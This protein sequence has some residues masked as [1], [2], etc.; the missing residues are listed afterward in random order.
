MQKKRILSG[1]RPTGDLHIGNYFG[2]VRQFVELQNQGHECFFFVADLHAL[3]TISK[4]TDLRGATIEIVRSYLACGLD[5][6][7]STIYCQSCLPEIPY[8]STLLGMATSES[9]LR[10]CTTFKEKSEKQEIVS[11]GLLSYPV[12][13]ATDILIVNSNIVPVGHDQLQHLEMTRDIAQKFNTTFGEVFAMPEARLMQAIRVPGLDGSGKMGKSDG[14]TISLFENPKS[15]I[16]KIKSAKTDLGPVAG[17]SM[18]PEIC[19]LFFLM[20]LCCP[21]EV[22]STYREKYNNLEQ[23]FYG[24]MKQDLA[25]YTVKFLEPFRDRYHSPECSAEAAADVL[26]QGRDKARPVASEVFASAYEKFSLFTP[27]SDLRS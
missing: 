8:L 2:A 6:A 17:Q 26:A 1:I 9:W 13:M 10:K 14:N 21:P 27:A 15:I 3:T 22:V 20:D 16:K 11:L 23:K 25:D 5:P 12:L 19:N 24:A 7:K 4:P 18:S